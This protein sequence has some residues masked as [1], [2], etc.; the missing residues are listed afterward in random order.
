MAGVHGHPGGAAEGAAAREFI[1]Y[2]EPQQLTMSKA[3]GA[4][5]VF[6]TR[7]IM[8]VNPTTVVVSYQA[9]GAD[10]LFVMSIKLESF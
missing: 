8:E 5:L 3:G 1:Q 2:W 4:K 6:S 7:T 10:Q 9:N